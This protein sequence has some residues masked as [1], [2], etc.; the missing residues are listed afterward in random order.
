LTV[1]MKALHFLLRF[2]VKAGRECLHFLAL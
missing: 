2:S 1:G